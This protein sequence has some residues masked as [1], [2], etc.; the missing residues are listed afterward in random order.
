MGADCSE[1]RSSLVLPLQLLETYA[2]CIGFVE[3]ED[4]A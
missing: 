3:A 1:K 4:D 2:Y